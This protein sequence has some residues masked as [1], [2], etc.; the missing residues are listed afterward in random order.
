MIS[1]VDLLKDTMLE[2]INRSMCEPV[3]NLLSN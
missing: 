1:P 2:R 3:N